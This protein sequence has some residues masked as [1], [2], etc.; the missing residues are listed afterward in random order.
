MRITLCGCGALGSWIGLF[1]AR[2][3]VS[4]LLIDD[5][6]VEEGNL[7]TSA[8]STQH[9]GMWKVDALAEMVW[10]K[11]GSDSVIE[12]RTIV[13]SNQFIYRLE[14]GMQEGII[15]DSFDNAQ[16]RVLTTGWNTLHV[17]VSEDRTGAIT[18]DHIYTPPPIRFP[19]GDNPI[20]TRQL[21]RGI[22]RM[23]ATIAATIVEDWIDRGV[24]RSVVVLENGRVIE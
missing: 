18:W 19:R 6:R 21:G 12:K 15:I 10:R 1:L 22:L 16:S 20:C 8:Y 9:V 13:N 4:F 23:T 2:P 11:G 24:Q 7:L 17:G 5:D 14:G 3:D